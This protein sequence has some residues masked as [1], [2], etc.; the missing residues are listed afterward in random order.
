MDADAAPATAFIPNAVF[1]AV[2]EIESPSLPEIVTSFAIVTASDM[3]PFV[4][5]QPIAIAL[6]AKLGL[7]A[8]PILVVGQTVAGVLAFQASRK[9]ANSKIVADALNSLDVETAKKFEE[10]RR[11]GGTED[12]SKVLAALI[13]LRLAPFFPFSAGNYLL[14]GATS[15]NIRPF[16]IATLFGCALSNVLNVSVGVGGGN[17]LSSI[18]EMI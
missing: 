15:V 12:E 5:C 9:T 7:A 6:S 1:H 18:Q 13:G 14:G 10:F 3:V 2:G 11:L 16:L 4:P 17:A 8:Y